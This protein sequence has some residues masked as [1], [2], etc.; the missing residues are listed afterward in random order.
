MDPFLNDNFVRLYHNMYIQY[1]CII[2]TVS[3]NYFS[4]AK[5]DHTLDVALQQYASSSKYIVFGWWRGGGGDL[6]GW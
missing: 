5:I 6:D 2:H 1:V 3:N 4:Y